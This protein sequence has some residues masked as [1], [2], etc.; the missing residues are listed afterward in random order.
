M[1]TIN[2]PRP[3]KVDN[4]I[5]SSLTY[6]LVPFVSECCLCL[7]YNC[8]HF[9]FFLTLHLAHAVHG[10]VGA[11][12]HRHLPHLSIFEVRL[13]LFYLR[14]MSYQSKE[15]TMSMS[16][17]SARTQCFNVNHCQIKLTM[18]MSMHFL[19]PALWLIP[20]LLH[21]TSTWKYCICVF[22]FALYLYYRCWGWSHMSYAPCLQQGLVNL[23]KWA[24]LILWPGPWSVPLPRCRGRPLPPSW[25]R[26]TWLKLKLR[27]PVNVKIS[28]HLTKWTISLPNFSW[29]IVSLNRDQELKFQ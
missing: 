14:S 28:W 2:P 8:V 4:H 12:H 22:V 10:V 17:V 25:W 7:I 18:S 1:L 26:H 20:A 13:H 23:R 9:P 21:Q 16:N 5:K 29:K 24:L 27:S 15:L 6:F 11:H 19:H 3:P